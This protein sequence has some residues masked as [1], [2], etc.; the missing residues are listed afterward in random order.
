MTARS[1]FDRSLFEL[2]G[3]P[4]RFALDPADL[5]A[6]HHRF[7]AVVH[8]DRHVGDEHGPAIEG[9]E[10]DGGKQLGAYR[11]RDEIGQSHLGRHGI[12]DADDAAIV[13]HADDEAPTRMISPSCRTRRRRVCMGRD[14]SPTSSRKMVPPSAISK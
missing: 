1:A 13:R 6:R 10:F 3:L 9:D 8:P 11:V 2:L 12:I 7:Q 4:E 5:E 14:S